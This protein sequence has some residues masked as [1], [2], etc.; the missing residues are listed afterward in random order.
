[1]RRFKSGEKRSPTSSCNVELDMQTFESS[2]FPRLYLG[3][4]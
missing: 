1:M 2:I 3:R 4:F